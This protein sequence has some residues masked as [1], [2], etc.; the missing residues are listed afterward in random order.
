MSGPHAVTPRSADGLGAALLI[1]L[2]LAGC[3]GTRPY[4]AT[5]DNNVRFTASVES[6]SFLSSMHAAA[7]IHSVDPSCRTHYVGTIPLGGSEIVT[8]IPAGRPSY[9]VVS[10]EGS[11]FLANRRSSISYETLLTPRPGYD[12]EVVVRYADDIYDTRISEVRRRDHARHELQR[13]PLNACREGQR[14]R[15]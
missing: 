4:D 14:A 9:L 12:Y 10:F 11:S 3:A 6:G 5:S 8:G 13:R 2:G 1:A 7:H 15:R